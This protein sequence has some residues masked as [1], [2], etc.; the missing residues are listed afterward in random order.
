M[1]HKFTSEHNVVPVTNSMHAAVHDW[2]Q[3]LLQACLQG[4]SLMHVILHL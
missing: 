3:F 4:R 1:K 2:P